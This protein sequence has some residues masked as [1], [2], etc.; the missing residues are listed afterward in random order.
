[1]KNKN[2]I[3]IKF[4]ENSRIQRWI[5]SILDSRVICYKY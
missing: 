2:S 5:R 3:L 4:V 1:M